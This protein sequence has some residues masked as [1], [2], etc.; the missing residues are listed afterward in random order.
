MCEACQITLARSIGLGGLDLANILVTL[1]L[2]CCI[3]TM[4]VAL[5]WHIAPGTVHV[6]PTRLEH[7]ALILCSP[8]LVVNGSGGGADW[9]HFV[10]AK[11]CERLVKDI[12]HGA[13]NDCSK[14]AARTWHI[15]FETL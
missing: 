5:S 3:W 14:A 6:Q 9:L 13:V 12:A 8:A 1:I 2:L 11:T 4:C 15:D 7:A 10:S